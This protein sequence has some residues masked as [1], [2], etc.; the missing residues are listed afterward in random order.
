[1]TIGILAL[2]FCLAI[3]AFKFTGIPAHYGDTPLRWLLGTTFSWHNLGCYV[4][5]VA[6]IAALDRG[7]LRDSDS[8]GLRR[9]RTRI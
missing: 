3:E 8:P 7:I 2:I 4:V 6:I 5:G 9:S 1:L